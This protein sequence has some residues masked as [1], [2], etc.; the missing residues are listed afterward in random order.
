MSELVDDT[1][2]PDPAR[3][4]ECGATLTDEEQAAV[5]LEGG[6]P[7]C[8]LHALETEPALADEEPGIA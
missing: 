8:K 1:L 3:C 7:L 4:G 5:L 6:P 2:P